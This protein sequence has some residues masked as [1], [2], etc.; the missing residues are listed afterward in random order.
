MKNEVKPCLNGDRLEKSIAE[1]GA[2]TSSCRSLTV[3][4]LCAAVAIVVEE[5]EVVHV[6]AAV[7]SLLLLSS[8]M[9]EVEVV[10]LEVVEV[11]RRGERRTA[12]ESS[13]I[14]NAQ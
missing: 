2:A 7:K 3:I 6:G 5:V 8:S 13:S 11:E 12:A 4:P 10:C 1:T 14:S 9:V